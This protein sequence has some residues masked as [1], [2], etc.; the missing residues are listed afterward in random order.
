ML[1]GKERIII[2]IYNFWVI[3]LY[4]KFMCIDYIRMGLYFFIMLN[5][6]SF[7]RYEN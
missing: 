7:A 2:N 6:L 5:E 1:E 4:I 3:V